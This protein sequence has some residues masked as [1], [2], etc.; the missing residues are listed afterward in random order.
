MGI[1][2][3]ISAWMDEKGGKEHGRLRVPKRARSKFKFSG[4]R[5]EVCVDGKSKILE[6]RQVRIEDL[7][8]LRKKIAAGKISKEKSRI[9][10]FV[11]TRTLNELVGRRRK[12]LEEYCYI[13]DSID[14]LLV[15]A[16]PE[17]CIVNPATGAYV[18]AQHVGGLSKTAQLGEDGPTVEVRPPPN[19]EPGLLVQKIG[20]IIKSHSKPIQDYDWFGGA[21]YYNANNSNK[22]TIHLG[23]HV[24]IG[25]P[26]LLRA[27]Q[28]NITYKQLVRILDE[29]VA[30][31]L[32]RIDTPIPEH[33]RNNSW[34]GYGNYGRWGDQKSQ[35]SRVEWRVPSGLWL[36]HPDLARAVVG[37]TKAV[38]EACYQQMAA[39]GFN[40]DYI[41]APGNRKGFLK[42]WGA[43][44]S[45]KVSQIINTAK[46]E[47]VSPALLSRATKK[48]RGMGTYRKYKSEIEE[49]LRLVKLSE[50]DR[51]N[52]NLD[53]KETW[54]N[55]GPLIK[56]N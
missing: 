29:V 24:H 52:I 39:N 35:A 56:G 25:D 12:N 9:C 10:A 34:N 54:L 27:D 22:R 17:F 32:V 26:K 20:D 23:G 13:S 42:D 53:L 37:T 21:A 50:R 1:R 8:K 15:G 47:G 28:R 3:L 49:F 38:A 2:L 45:D 41:S 43:M 33:R 18:Y 11:T 30:L 48:L 44:S 31:P 51:K 5:T 7:E 46:P 36:V 19:K 14:S 55:N 4:D 40:T 16:D 6:V